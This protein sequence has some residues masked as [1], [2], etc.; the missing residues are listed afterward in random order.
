METGRLKKENEFF[1]NAEEF[2]E[3]VQN[4]FSKAISQF[5]PLDSDPLIIE[6]ENTSSRN[7]K[8]CIFI[9]S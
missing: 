3:A 9:I 7:R 4:P 2:S 6:F 5:T 8:L 1:P